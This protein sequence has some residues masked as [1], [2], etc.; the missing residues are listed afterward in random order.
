MEKMAYY[1]RIGCSK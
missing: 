1:C